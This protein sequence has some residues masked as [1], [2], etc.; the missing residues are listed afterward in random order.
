MDLHLT[1][2]LI[3]T[4]FQATFIKPDWNTLMEADCAT[5]ALYCKETKTFFVYGDCV[6]GAPEESIKSVIRALSDLGYN[7]KVENH[8]AVIEGN[9]EDALKYFQ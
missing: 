3:I 5:H 1:H 6:D 8:V 2:V 7:I 4:P 9:K